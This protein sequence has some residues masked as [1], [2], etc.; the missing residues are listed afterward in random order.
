MSI[1]N[2]DTN[3]LAYAAKAA[4]DLACRI[5]PD[6]FFGQTPRDVERAKALCTGCPLQE[7]CLQTAIE[8]AEPWGVW[9]G[10]LIERGRIV[11]F[12]RGRGRP[13]KNPE[14]A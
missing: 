4:R 12:K 2:S 3:E 5:E 10:Q 9:G 6:L 7:L 8:T 1:S 14:A 11:P 13:R